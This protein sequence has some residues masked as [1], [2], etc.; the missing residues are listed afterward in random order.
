MG[1]RSKIPFKFRLKNFCQLFPLILGKFRLWLLKDQ[2][3]LVVLTIV[4][5]GNG[6]YQSY[7]II[8][9]LLKHWKKFQLAFSQKKKKG[10]WKI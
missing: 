10:S 3:F 4:L 2:E 9:I 5:F 7:L 1:Q 8:S 6:I